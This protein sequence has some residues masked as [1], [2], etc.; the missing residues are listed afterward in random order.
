MNDN[1][2]NASGRLTNDDVRKK[3]TFQNGDNDTVASLITEKDKL[4]LEIKDLE[5]KCKEEQILM[6]E[7]KGSGIEGL[8]ALKSLGLEN[9]R[10]RS[11][12][13]Q[14]LAKSASE[15][16]QMTQ[17]DGE[18]L[19]A[20]LSDQNKYIDQQNN[21][22][23]G[24]AEEVEN[25]DKQ[26]REL[27]KAVTDGDALNAMLIYELQQYTNEDEQKDDL[28]LLSTLDNFSQA[29][30]AVTT[31]GMLM[32]EKVLG[33]KLPFKSA[34]NSPIKIDDSS[35]TNV[36]TEGLIV[37]GEYYQARC[38]ALEEVV[39]EMYKDLRNALTKKIF[40][41]RST[42]PRFQISSP[43]SN[44][45]NAMDTNK[46]LVLHD[47]MLSEGDFIVSD[48]HSDAHTEESEKIRTQDDVFSLGDDVKYKLL[49]HGDNA[50]LNLSRIEELEQRNRNLVQKLEKE[51]KTRRRLEDMRKQQQIEMQTLRKSLK[52]AEV[53]KTTRDV[54][55]VMISR[56]SSQSSIS[57]EGTG[58][59]NGTGGAPGGM[60]KMISSNRTGYNKHANHDPSIDRLINISTGIS[61]PVDA[62]DRLLL[63][64]EI[65]QVRFIFIIFI[66]VYII[67]FCKIY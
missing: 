9:K 42:P 53:T 16:K 38:L 41:N 56:G 11:K 58:T 31:Q 45:A 34:G 60:Q 32:A 5:Y 59:G 24:A 65:V 52:C 63:G 47:D 40:S 15:K 48:V 49:S 2:K 66:L 33:N 51:T 27:K 10:I 3:L 26:I 13:K 17:D 57:I 67:L 46:E 8:V 18:S 12:Y 14:V 35:L 39:F 54:E 23:Q 37:G 55:N 29:Q 7:I 64:W 61:S 4:L 28:G 21:F 44:N 6:E 25:L 36:S 30:G 1:T 20:T 19:R 22:L 50:E 62:V 43:N